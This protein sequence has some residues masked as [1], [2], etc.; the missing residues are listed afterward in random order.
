MKKAF[1]TLL[2]LVVIA[3]SAVFSI[4]YY[5]FNL[6]DP[7]NAINQSFRK[8]VL[9]YPFLRKILRLEQ[10]GD[11]RFEYMY[12][13]ALPLEVFLYYQDGTSLEEKT[14]ESIQREMQYATHKYVDIT[15]HE[16]QILYA[17]PDKVTDEDIAA[18]LD[19]YAHDTAIGSNIVPLHIF[20]LNYY[21]PHPSF[22][23]MVSDAHSLVL[24][25]DAMINVSENQS[26]VV[27]VE[28]STI[29]HEFAHLGG[30]EH[31]ENTD[32]ILADTVE[33]LD[34]YNKIKTIRDSYC[35]EDLEAIKKALAL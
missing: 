25:K 7:S 18:V 14:L 6:T 3:L 35:D 2:L 27:A 10:L 33:N 22:A 20:L 11:A 31:I 9:V 23:G 15:V 4:F 12:H 21:T 29:L 28:I 30:A 17:V 16:P 8:R 26:S 5:S 19:M 13:R 32:C 24:F 1:V 34:F